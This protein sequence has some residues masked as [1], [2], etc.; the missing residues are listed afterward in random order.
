MFFRADADIGLFT[1][2]KVVVPPLVE[3]ALEHDK[4]QLSGLQMRK[5][6]R[7][8]VDREKQLVFRAFKKTLDLWDQ[9]PIDF[10]APM[11]RS[12]LGFA[13]SRRANSASLYWSSI[14]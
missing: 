6:V 1:Q 2:Q 4:V 9:N 14:A 13:A 8:V 11:R 7:G 12:V 3:K 10:V 5:K